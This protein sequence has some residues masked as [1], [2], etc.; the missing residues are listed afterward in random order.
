MSIVKFDAKSK[1]WSACDDP[2]IYNPN[3]SVGHTLLRSLELFGPKLAQVR[4]QSQNRK[5][6]KITMEKYQNKLSIVDK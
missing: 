2:S 5:H 1:I 6:T 3:I 4:R